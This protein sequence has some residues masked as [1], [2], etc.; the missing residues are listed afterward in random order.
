VKKTLY[1][2]ISVMYHFFQILVKIAEINLIKPIFS[3]L[4]QN[5]ALKTMY[6]Q[7]FLK[8]LFENQN[9]QFFDVYFLPIGGYNHN[10]YNYNNHNNDENHNEYH[11]NK[12]SNNNNKFTRNDWPCAIHNRFWN[13]YFGRLEFLLYFSFLHPSQLSTKA[14]HFDISNQIDPNYTAAFCRIG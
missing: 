4:D 7:K 13:E 5:F 2:Q 12:N 6:C 3:F 9:F 8:K 11:N 10:F 1:I 14:P